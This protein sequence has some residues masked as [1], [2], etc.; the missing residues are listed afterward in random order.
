[1]FKIWDPEWHFTAENKGKGKGSQHPKNIAN[2]V[3]RNSLGYG[4]VWRY[5]A[6]VPAD[7]SGRE[8]QNEFEW[9]SVWNEEADR[10]WKLASRVPRGR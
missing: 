9:N 6:D 10:L 1:M 8:I 4:L 3:H 5:V 7:T 2:T